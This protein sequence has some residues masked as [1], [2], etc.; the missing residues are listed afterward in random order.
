MHDNH[1]IG[2]L[3]L[4]YGPLILMAMLGQLK[5][6]VEDKVVRS[7]EQVVAAAL[8]SFDTIV[9]ATVKAG[10]WRACWVSGLIATLLR[11]IPRCALFKMYAVRGGAACDCEIQF[12]EIFM[13]LL[14]AEVVTKAEDQGTYLVWAWKV[15][16]DGAE[17]CT[18][19]LQQ[20]K[21]VEDASVGSLKNGFLPEKDVAHAPNLK[22]CAVVSAPER[23][24]AGEPIAARLNQNVGDALAA[25]K[26]LAARKGFLPDLI[27]FADED[28]W[29]EAYDAY[30]EN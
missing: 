10:N 20:Y 17:D 14:G 6:V 1:P 29:G 18:V 16:R 30:T 21:T 25:A 28:E 4:I 15:K 26:E 12:I 22:R 5:A 7:A 19:M 13:E 8:G 27:D 24:I 2:D 9:L 3:W 23:D 11:N